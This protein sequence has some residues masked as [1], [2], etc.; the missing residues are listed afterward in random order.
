MIRTIFIMLRAE[1]FAVAPWAVISRL[2]ERFLGCIHA[3]LLGWKASY[4]GYGARIIGSQAISVKGYAYINRCCW[5]EAVH[6]FR[7]Q[8]FS[9]RISIGRGLSVSDRLHLSC[10]GLVEIGDDCLFGSNVYISDHNHGSYSGAV[11][12]SPSIAPVDRELVFTGAVAIGSRVWIGDN[13]VIIGPVRIGDGAVIGAH[14][15]VKGDVPPN[16]L[17]VGTPAVVRKLFNSS[18]G[19]WDT[20]STLSLRRD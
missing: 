11:H 16:S 13:V 12:S 17:V 10:I 5:I 20:V 15:V 7:G 3:K 8:H 19:L 1:R 14:S 9:P 18:T 4:I 2:L 6:R